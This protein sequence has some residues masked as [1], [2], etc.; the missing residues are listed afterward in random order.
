MILISFDFFKRKMLNEVEAAE[1]VDRKNLAV[2][3]KV[4]SK[5]DIQGKDR[6]EF[7]K[8]EGWTAVVEK[9]IHN[10]G[11]LVL[12]I[13]YDSVVPKRP[14]FSFLESSKYRVK[15][16]RF[17][18]KDGS[19]FSSVIVLSEK[20]LRTEF[21]E[22]NGNLTEGED[23]T[24][25]IGV[26]KYIPQVKD[27]YG[28]QLG[29]LSKI[30]DFPT[31]MLRKSDET[32]LQSKIGML[33]EFIG[34]PY[35]ITVKV[36][37]SS[38]TALL[39]DNVFSVCSRN[40]NLRD[41]P[42]CVFWLVAKKYKLEEIL[43]NIPG[44]YAIQGEVCGPKIQNNKLGLKESDFIVFSIIDLEVRKR[45]SFQEQK[46]FC[47]KHGLKHVPVVSEGTDFQGSIDD[48]IRMA[49][50]LK[51]EG[52]KNPIEGIVLRPL[53]EKW[54]ERLKEPLSCKIMNPLY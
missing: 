41:E 36:D 30:S 37:G 42:T 34:N 3:C 45:I 26:K 8:V 28:T 16:K 29:N 51:Y 47:V 43:R 4:V 12:V 38:M 22:I 14:C 53:E 17:S 39:I 48:L 1:I 49:S 25:K 31:H 44:R 19:V 21:P 40:V 50:E 23:F 33:K 35:Y 27:I 5:E 46:D 13:R 15:P 9:G 10:V 2:I 54:N 20:E 11:D 24:D 7:L 52:T 18:T 6:I 32:N